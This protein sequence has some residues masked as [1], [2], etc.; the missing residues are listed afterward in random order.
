MSWDAELEFT[1]IT[2]PDGRKLVTLADARQHLLNMRA[3]A[4]SQAAAGALLL[5]ANTPNQLTCLL[6]R[7]A[8]YKAIYG[9]TVKTKERRETWRDRRRARRP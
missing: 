7:I 3:T 8:V 6:A 4:A 5:A 2:T 1:P 9:E